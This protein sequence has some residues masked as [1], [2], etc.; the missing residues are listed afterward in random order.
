MYRMSLGIERLPRRKI[1]DRCTYCRRADRFALRNPRQ[2][3]DCLLQPM[4]AT[5]T[6]SGSPGHAASPLLHA[7]QNGGLVHGNAKLD[8]ETRRL[9]LQPAE[10]VSILDNAL[11]N[12]EPGTEV[13][14]VG[15]RRH[16]DCVGE[17]VIVD[18][19]RR[20]FGDSLGDGL[21]AMPAHRQCLT[22]RRCLCDDI[23]SA[24]GAVRCLAK[25]EA[26][27]NT[28]ES[29]R[30]DRHRSLLRASL[31]CLP[32]WRPVATRRCPPARSELQLKPMLQ[33]SATIV[34]LHRQCGLEHSQVRASHSYQTHQCL[35]S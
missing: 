1:V 24:L 21:C 17:S 11:G 28:G 4:D 3:D 31:Q 12:A 5:K 35:P 18:P 32:V 7:T 14:E 16:H 25:R 27:G 22:L 19:D 30:V 10:L 33:W 26:R 29:R 34:A 23:R 8:A 13:L 9:D 20:L 6:A 2:V 15:W